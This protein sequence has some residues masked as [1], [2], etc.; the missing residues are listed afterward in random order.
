MNKKSVQEDPPTNVSDDVDPLEFMR[1]QEQKLSF[2][3]RVRD[4]K[5]EE[6][7]RSE[8]IERRRQRSRRCGVHA[9]M[10][11]SHRFDELLQSDYVHEVIRRSDKVDYGIGTPS[12]SNSRSAVSARG[13]RTYPFTEGNVRRHLA[14]FDDYRLFT[15]G[16]IVDEANAKVIHVTLD[17]DNGNHR[18]NSVSD[19]AKRVD[20][21]FKALL[22]DADGFCFSQRSSNNN[23]YHSHFS[24]SFPPRTKH[25]NIRHELEHLRALIAS[26]YV[27]SGCHEVCLKGLPMVRKWN[28]DGEKV[29]LDIVG[30][31]YGTL[32]RS[33]L[34]ASNQDMLSM[35]KVWYQPAPIASLLR[36]FSLGASS[37]LDVPKPSSPAQTAYA[38]AVPS[39]STR[40]SADATTTAAT[41]SSD[42]VDNSAVSGCQQPQAMASDALARMRRACYDFLE[43]HGA[44]PSPD[45]LVDFYEA[46]GFH[47]PVNDGVDSR[48]RRLERAHAV[49]PYVVTHRRRTISPNVCRDWVEVIRELK[50]PKCRRRCGKSRHVRPE[51]IGVVIGVITQMVEAGKPY[52]AG[53]FI[54][55]EGRLLHKTNGIYCKLDRRKVGTAARIAC[56]LGIIDA[57][58]A[59]RPGVAT[60]YAIGKNNHAFKNGHGRA[61]IDAQSNPAPRIDCDSVGNSDSLVSTSLDVSRTPPI[62][63]TETAKPSLPLPPPP[64]LESS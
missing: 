4:A 18:S 2:E 47:T 3:A 64:P 6:R 10:I 8:E 51:E 30:S 17:V 29:E 57:V 22:N 56:E 63:V 40:S 32:V 60:K 31:R 44:T 19:E 50:L 26:V 62:S 48:E 35:M 59:P 36:T 49:I 25:A 45:A 11:L 13:G 39:S 27:Q 12:R 54:E 21:E 24:V 34:P 7:L 16:Q 9:K 1:R 61:I 5:T 41:A 37:R 58:Q 20:G 38:V 23:G 14:G 42:S 33:P 28:R 46:H 43:E 15:C 53:T 52:V 55:T